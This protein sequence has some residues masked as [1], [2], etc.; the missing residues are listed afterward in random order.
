[1][2]IAF[3]LPDGQVGSIA[4]PMQ[5]DQYTEGEEYGG[6]VAR[7]INTPDVDD[8]T[9]LETWYWKDN[10]WKKDKTACPSN[11]HDWVDYA[12]VWNSTKFWQEV[13][14]ARDA[15]LLS[16]DWTQAADAPFT[17]EKKAEWAT[18]RQAVRDVPANNSS[19][20]DMDSIVWPTKP[21]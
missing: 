19:V 3:T 15:K 21:S 5:P 8:L 13:R 11:Y 16:T 2:R 14:H 6:A 1:M 17:A 4:Y 10:E 20:T 12:W 18:Y 7:F 9:I